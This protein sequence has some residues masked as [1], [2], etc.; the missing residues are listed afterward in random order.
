MGKTFVSHA[1]EVVV[2][3]MFEPASVANLIEYWRCF[4]AVFAQDTGDFVPYPVRLWLRN[5]AR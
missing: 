5:P 4:T 3:Q 1:S 2:D